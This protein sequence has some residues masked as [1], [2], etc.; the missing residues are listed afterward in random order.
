MTDDPTPIPADGRPHVVVVGAG[1][2]GLACAKTL[3][4][5]PGGGGVRVTVID[6]NNYHLF[7]PLLYQVATAALSPADIATPIRSILSRYPNVDVILGAVEGV[8]TAARRVRLAGGRAVPYDRLV[9][10]TGSVY[11][12]FGHDDWPHVA[13]ALKTVENARHIRTRLLSAL[14]EAEMCDDADRRAALMTVVIVGGGPTGVEMAG[15][16]AELTRFTLAR[17]FRRI[18]PRAARVLLVEAGPRILSAFP[19]HLAAYARRKLEA[20]GVTVMTGQAVERIDA[21]GVTVGGRAIPAATVV[22][23]AGVA[24]SP[25]GRWL[26]VDT[27]RAGRIR[28]A[29][30]L[31]VPG[32]PG[33]YALGDTAAAAD[34]A[35]KPL[36]GLAQVA[37][38]QGEHLGRALALNLTAGT[39]PAPFR[40]RNRGNTAI[41]GRNAAIFDFGHRTLKG[42]FAWVLWAIVH[43]YLLV[44][45]E[46]RLSVTLRWLWRYATYERGARLITESPPSDVAEV[47]TQDNSRRRA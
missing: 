30:D 13:P 17:D 19:E 40:F 36:P 35:G 47:T 12:Y 4:R 45:G 10:A 46:K 8:D 28:V 25:A 44:G 32:V 5:A 23:G 38:Q 20:L 2:G 31:S 6:R 39:A 14:E 22:W 9:L 3:A 21:T 43:V 7:V 41:I 11:S 37:K 18:D 34:D 29:P 42:W 1:F 16:V 15:A 33:V 26:G 27:D 24:A